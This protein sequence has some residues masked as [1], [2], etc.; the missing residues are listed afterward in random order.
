MK[1][2]IIDL[3][4]LLNRTADFQIGGTTYHVREIS[5]AQFERMIEIERMDGE[6]AV[7]AQVQFLSDVMSNNLEGRAFE[8]DTVRTWQKS[9]LLKIWTVLVA[10]STEIAALPN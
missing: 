8:P 9:V 3:D 1:K 4:E 6:E 10:R 5:M 7:A 2:N